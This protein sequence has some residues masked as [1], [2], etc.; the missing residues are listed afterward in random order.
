MK[1]CA[2]KMTHQAE[3]VSK[4]CHSEIC[5]YNKKGKVKDITIF[6]LYSHYICHMID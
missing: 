4:S 1:M 5:F 2:I 3:G 6:Q